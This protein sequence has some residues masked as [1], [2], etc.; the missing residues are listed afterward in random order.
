MVHL[1]YMILQIEKV[2]KELKIGLKILMNL[3]QKILLLELLE[4]KMILKKIDKLNMKKEKIILIIIMLFFLKLVLKM[5]I[6]LMLLFNKWLIK[7]LK[8]YNKVLLMIL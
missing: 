7:Y 2:L 6:I 5:E 1:L 8:K 3:H 4:I